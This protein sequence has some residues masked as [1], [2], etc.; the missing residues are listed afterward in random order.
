MKE[1]NQN[2]RKVSSNLFF[3]IIILVCNIQICYS[4]V[5][6]A[7]VANIRVEPSTTVEVGELVFFDAT[8]STDDSSLVAM[9]MDGA[10]GIFEWDF[11]DGYVMKI[12]EPYFYSY[13]TGISCVHYFM[14]PGTYEVALI[15][16]DINENKDTATVTMHV[17]G[18]APMEGFELW[19]APYHARISQYIYAQI[20]DETRNERLRVTIENDEGYSAVLLDKDVLD[21]EERFL[22]DHSVLPQG[23][24]A[25][26][27]EIINSSGEVITYIKEKFSKPYNGIP[28][29]GI[30]K[31]N[32]ICIEGEP[33]F[34]VTPCLLNN[35]YLEEW[36]GKY[37]NTAYMEGYYDTH[38]S[39]T[40]GDY[41]DNCAAN[42]IRAIGPE[43]W[44][45]KA[46]RHCE[47]NSD[48]NKIAEY[49]TANNSNPGLL[50][51]M[52][53]DE[54]SLGG[55]YVRIISQVLASWTFKSHQLDF[56]HPVATQHYGY[57]YLPYYGENGNAAGQYDYLQNAEWFGG[58]K[59]FPCDVIGDDIYPLEYIEHPSLIDPDR[60]L[61]D[62]WVESI[63]ELVSRNYDLIPAM[64]F[65]EVQDVHND[66]APGPTPGQLRMEI[67][68][69]VVHGMK[70]INWFHY[71]GSTPQENLD[72][73]ELFLDQITRLT[74]VVLGEK[75]ERIVTDNANTRGNR[76][77]IMV[78]ETDT[79]IYVFAVR[80]TE[81]DPDCDNDGVEHEPE[82]IAVE[83]NIGNQYSTVL[84]VFDENRNIEV[85]NGYFTDTFN[86]C[87]VHIY[88]IPKSTSDIP[89]DDQIT[90]QSFKIFPNPI[91]SN[92]TIAYSLPENSDVEISLFDVTGRKVQ[93]LFEG[94][95][96]AGEHTLDVELNTIE[97]GVFFFKLKA[98]TYKSISKCIITH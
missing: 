79:T 13:E 31:N 19:H 77:D 3:G 8:G 72:E 95:Q 38:N 21:A 82:K 84:R 93:T 92:T 41:L 12:G 20:P 76:V 17:T 44:E 89:K 24:Y 75:P 88:V 46:P 53:D 94:H 1:K 6:E 14:Q 51:W 56:Q 2:F 15:L 23:N 68:L 11:G 28:I 22:L 60:G 90:S 65:I 87:A 86:I 45:G 29:V 80:L 42:N 97:A 36:S 25:I 9:E 35:A 70:G 83:F 78:R 39:S 57:G 59:H 62:L 66:G 67:W 55:R 34:L 74:P 33:S 91:K 10:Q 63:D 73:I 71:F 98:G 5:G 85:T 52:W 37:I 49:V 48:V 40:W 32:A 7:P 54:P 4:Q 64:Q 50:M 30:N 47:R 27:A 43:R 61:F 81:P 69:S 18:D 16:T 96:I 26:F 58:K